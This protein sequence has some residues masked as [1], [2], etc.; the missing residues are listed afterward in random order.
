MSSIVAALIG[1]GVAGLGNALNSENSDYANRWNWATSQMNNRYNMLMLQKQ[2]DYNTSMWDRQNAY[3]TP[4]SQVK[5]LK[6]AGINPYL[7]L[8]NIQT[9]QAG[10]AGGVN[11]PSASP[12]APANVP[13]F[14]T[15]GL[16]S[17]IQNYVAN[18]LAERQVDSSTSL[19]DAN[20][21]QVRIE[22]QYKA[23]DLATQLMERLEN[24][25]SSR[26]KN[27]YQSMLN[28][29]YMEQFNSDML[30]AQR[31][32][33]MI[34]AGIREKFVDIAIK[35]IN[36]ANLPQQYRLTFASV[37]ADTQLKLAQGDLSRQQA[38]H[39]LQKKWKTMQE[40]YNIKINNRI[41][42]ATI[43]DIIDKTHKENVGHYWQMGADALGSV[44]NGVLGFGL[45]R[46]GKALDGG[47]RIIT[48]NRYDDR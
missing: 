46:I 21:A 29:T 25:K 28:D 18:R 10:S 48:Y 8:G 7:A 6:D 45:G 4:S 41:L 14:D 24:T 37:A 5:R 47:R 43:N 44:V 22:N 30:T 36:L 2:M 40:T 35:E 23:M 19:Q 12:V 42:D 16:Q 34:E 31:N 32:R 17:S 15:S 39:E 9:G 3:N 20:A 27:I 38:F 1:A 26:L 13:Q 33:E 11:P